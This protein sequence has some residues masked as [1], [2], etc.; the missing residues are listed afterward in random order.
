MSNR[1]KKYLEMKKI[2]VSK[3]KKKREFSDLHVLIS[4]SL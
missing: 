2:P 1:K 4:S 3:E